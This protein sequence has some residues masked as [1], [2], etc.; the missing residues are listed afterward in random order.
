[1]VCFSGLLGQ[2][3]PPVAQLKQIR[4]S[5][6]KKIHICGRELAHGTP[7][8][9]A[10]GAPPL[11]GLTNDQSPMYIDATFKNGPNQGSFDDE[12]LLLVVR[13]CFFLRCWLFS[14]QRSFGVCQSPIGNRNPGNSRAG[15][16]CTSAFPR[17]KQR[18]STS[19][20]RLLWHEAALAPRQSRTNLMLLE[21]SDVGG[22]IILQRN[23][24]T[25]NDNAGARSGGGTGGG[26][27]GGVWRTAGS[28]SMLMFR[29]SVLSCSIQR[30][31][32]R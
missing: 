10:L 16:R 26:H 11:M 19:P 3:S 7:P 29:T 1:M 18:C 15:W 9:I 6:E 12:L 4:L 17:H 5:S 27:S 22:N 14:F 30:T 32:A 20:P 31:F 25:I 8:Q 21:N 23:T 2:I 13:R 28:R 24:V